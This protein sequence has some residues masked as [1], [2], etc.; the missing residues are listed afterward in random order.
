MEKKMPGTHFEGL[1]LFEEAG[2][3]ARVT[4]QLIFPNKE[5]RDARLRA[6]LPSRS[7]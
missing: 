2:Q 4:I 5:A 1:W 3:Q 7:E 6:L